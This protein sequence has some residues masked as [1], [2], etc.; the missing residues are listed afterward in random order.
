[1]AVTTFEEAT[2]PKA[3]QTNG[4]A[5]AANASGAAVVPADGYTLG[6]PHKNDFFERATNLLSDYHKNSYDGSKPVIALRSP[7]EIENEFVKAGVPLSLTDGAPVD[8]AAILTAMEKTLE[9][10]VRMN[11]PLFLNQLTAGINSIGL[12]GE[13]LI[14][15]TNTNA[16]TY[17]VAPVFTMCERFCIDKAARMWLGTPAGIATPSHDGLFTP[18]GSFS[19]M[20]GFLMARFKAIPDIKT[21]GMFG[22]GR[23]LVAFCSAD[24]HYSSNKSAQVVGLGSDNLRKVKVNKNGEM[25]VESLKA[26]IAKAVERNEL[27]FLVVATAGST[28]LGAFDPI[29]AIADVCKEH[30]MWMHVDAAWGGGTLLS[31]KLRGELMKGV[32]RA[33]SLTWNP[34]K[35]MNVPLSC[36]MF[37]CKYEGMLK[38]CNGTSASYLFQPD[39][40]YSKYDVGDKTIQCGRK[41]DAYKLWLVWKNTGDA[42]WRSHIEHAY[43]LTR[44]TQKKI[45]A[46]SNFVMVIDNQC[47]NVCFWY[48]PKSMR[49][50]NPHT[51]TEEE[52]RKLGAVAPKL[53]ARLQQAGGA[54]IGFQPLPSHNIVNFWRV[55]FAGADGLTE[56]IVDEILES[57]ETLGHDL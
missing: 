15:A 48:L 8:E 7:K 51:A 44:Y 6:G 18:G 25:C 21:K 14:G 23:Q 35:M 1:M 26:E 32:E 2:S 45:E 34:H 52:L 50:I 36:S 47:T 54:M 57:F 20:Y 28:V 46:S 43:H 5:A 53:K 40:L 24:A 12:A 16:H 27:P 49:H 37:I 42:G 9:L 30:K 41:P 10:G 3:V 11:H 56:K 19:N 13:W 33:D 4:K 31:P 22:C 38:E 29:D 17:E 39:K 55:V